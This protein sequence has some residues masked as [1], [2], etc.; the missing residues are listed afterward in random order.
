MKGFKVV[1][2]NEQLEQKPLVFT[3]F[4]A[5]GIGKTSLSFTAEKPVIFFDFDKGVQRAS[6]NVRPDYVSVTDIKVFMDDIMGDEFTAFVKENGYKTAVVDTAGT[7]LDD[8]LATYVKGL[9]RKNATSSGGLSL[10]GWGAIK[11]QFNNVRNRLQNLGMNIIFVCHDKDQG[12]DSPI[13]MGLSVSGSSSDIIMRVS[14]QI[15]YMY[16]EGKDIFINFSPRQSLH[17]AKDTA[18]IGKVKVPLDTTKG[19][20]GFL[21]HVMNECHKRIAERS[22]SQIEAQKTID[23]YTALIAKC[24]EPADFAELTEGI[25]ALKGAVAIQVKA[26]FKSRMQET[27]VTW[28]KDSEMYVQAKTEDDGKD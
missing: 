2:S 19:Y 1:R 8:Y 14:D 27:G 17:I 4:G 18:K 13:K 25:K 5:P 26:A 7:F 21:G 22:Q 9:D 16:P 3:I 10:A 23:D 12:D 6:Q 11:E 15:G 24:E 20:E 28:D